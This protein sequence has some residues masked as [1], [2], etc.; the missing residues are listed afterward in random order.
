MRNI[1]I[2][3]IFLHSVLSILHSEMALEATIQE[4]KLPL[5][6]DSSFYENVVK[7]IDGGMLDIDTL[8]NS[9]IANNIANINKTLQFND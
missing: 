8:L 9:L 7:L 5:Q 4:L 6:K 2:K 1:D 3:K